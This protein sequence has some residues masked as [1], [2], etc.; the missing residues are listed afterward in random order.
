MLISGLGGTVSGAVT[1]FGPFVD[2][3]GTSI[4]VNGTFDSGTAPWA[5]YN[6]GSL[7][8]SA[9][10][11]VFS[12]GGALSSFSQGVTGYGG[13][14][15]RYRVTARLGTSTNGHNIIATTNNAALSAGIFSGSINTTAANTFE[16]YVSTAGGTTTWFGARNSNAAGTGTAIF[17][18]ATAVEAWPFQGFPNAANANYFTEEV[19]RE[20]SERYGEKKLYEGGLSVRTTLDPKMQALARKALVD[21]LVRYDQ[22][23]GW[24]GPVTKVDLTGRDWGM[25]AAEV[26]A[27]GD[28]APWRLAVVLGQG[29]GG[30]QIGL[31]PKRR[32][33]FL[34]Q[35]PSKYSEPVGDI[36]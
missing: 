17:D 8:A 12:A 32:S 3:T 18:N 30:V 23:H 14:A 7:A 1:T 4:L 5:A 27:L 26:N 2:P 33:A 29:G 19:R 25:A 24:R 11:L 6:G 21:G 9:G 34:F 36:V 16:V 22:S 35:P 31:Q 10:E 15:F 20:I 28:V 13:R